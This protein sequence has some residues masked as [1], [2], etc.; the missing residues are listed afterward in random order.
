MADLN[1]FF[2]IDPIVEGNEDKRLFRISIDPQ[3]E[4]FAGHFPN[5]PIVPGVLI[6]KLI[7][8]CSSLVAG[9]SLRLSKVTQ[10]KFL[11][12]ID[13]RIY[14]TLLLELTIYEEDD[15]RDVKA[16]LRMDDMIFTKASLILKENSIV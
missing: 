5:Q 11:N 2:K 10:C 16:V 12:F 8:S 9:I 15:M 13:P 6:I 7:V 3:H 1:S 4:V 14:P